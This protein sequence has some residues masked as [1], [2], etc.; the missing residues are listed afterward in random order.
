MLR[1]AYGYKVPDVA[2]ALRVFG[3]LPTVTVDTA[4]VVAE[5]WTGLKDMDLADAL[6]RR[7]S[8]NCDTIHFFNIY[9][10]N[11]DMADAVKTVGEV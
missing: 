2:R 10:I 4:A 6:H 8:G 5:G 3:G 9:F 7:S 11:A 1:C